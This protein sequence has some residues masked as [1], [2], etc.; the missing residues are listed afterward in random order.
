MIKT[1]LTLIDRNNKYAPS[2]IILESTTDRRDT[3]NMIREDAFKREM[4][5]IQ[6]ANNGSD[7]QIERALDL[8]AITVIKID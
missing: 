2:N 4:F 7:Y 5:E 1:L 8:D 6:L 3:S